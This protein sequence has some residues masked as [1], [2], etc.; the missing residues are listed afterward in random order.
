VGSVGE[1]EQVGVLVGC[2]GGKFRK[3]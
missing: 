3:S 2:V 1:N